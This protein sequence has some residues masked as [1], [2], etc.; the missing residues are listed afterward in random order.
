ADA[1]GPKHLVL[2]LSRAKLES[3]VDDL[4]TR[5]LEPCRA[6]LKDAGVT[7]SEIQEVILVGGMTRM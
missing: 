2:K 5:T 1:S 4:I 3:L 7:A 6:A